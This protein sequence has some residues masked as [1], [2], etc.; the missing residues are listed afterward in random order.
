M[1]NTTI[2]DNVRLS[3]CKPLLKWVGGKTQLLDKI[4]PDF[5]SEINN[6]R[7]IFLGGGSVL[8]AL[9]SNIKQGNIKLTGN[10]YAY[11][12][13]GP[14]ISMYK[15]VQ[16][17]HNELYD[18]L[19]K[20][21]NE[22]K[23]C[24]TPPHINSDLIVNRKPLNI[25]DAKLSK[26]NYYYWIRTKYNKLSDEDKN[27]VLGSA[28]FVFLNKTCFRGLFR[29]GPNGFNVP[30]GN[31]KN[32]EIVNKIHLDEIHELFNLSGINVSFE[33]CD[34]ETSINQVEPNDFMYID[35]PYAPETTTSF[36][37]Y[38]EQGFNID[39]HHRLFDNIINQSNVFDN[40]KFMMSNADVKLVRDYFEHKYNTTSVIC[41]R[42]I[43]S[44]KPDANTKEIII[45]NY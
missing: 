24:E 36:V 41:K 27:T 2:T 5:P 45:K 26:E 31:Y 14:L 25:E 21:I 8:L 13:N 12:L 37:K 20:L 28:M 18:E 23:M 38:T 4:I 9:L 39:D 33:C 3:I 10:V 29:I 43:N 16:S 35:P 42:S 44:K 34:F 6:Y 40:V 19:Q 11:D 1:K 30:Y 15:N 32:P 22:Y 17:Y 7:E